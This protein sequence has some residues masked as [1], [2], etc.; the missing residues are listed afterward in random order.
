MSLYWHSSVSNPLSFHLLMMLVMSCESL[1]FSIVVRNN[2]HELFSFKYM[3]EQSS[4]GLLPACQLKIDTH[5]HIQYTSANG[6]DHTNRHTHSC[7][8]PVYLF[9]PKGCLTIF[10]TLA[11]PAMG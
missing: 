8:S 11:A 6:N 9:P 4:R 1:K 3:L 2:F 10:G 5:E 7:T